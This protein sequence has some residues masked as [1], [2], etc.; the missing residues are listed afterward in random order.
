MDTSDKHPKINI[1][2]ATPDWVM[3]LL[4]LAFLVLLIAL[5][6]IY[7]QSLPERIPIHFNGAGQPDGYGNR[8]SI[9][10]L[11]VTGI[12]LYLLLSVISAFPHIYNF[13][14]KITND[15]AEVQ[16]RIATRLIRVLKVLILL[17]FCFLSF[18][19]IRTAAGKAAG[20]GKSFL[21]VFLLLT[22]G[23]IV[24]YIVVSLNNRRHS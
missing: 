6:F 1:K 18:Q 10:I 21:P 3:E 24:F 8:S 14:V 15:N 13:P 22:F 23:V 12:F 20:L 7:L 2:L 19:T 9:W 5:P 4:A 16:Y 17:L 11:P